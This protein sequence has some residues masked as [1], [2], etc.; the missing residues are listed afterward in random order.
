[1]IANWVPTGAGAHLRGRVIRDTQPELRLRRAVHA[2]GLRFRLNQ[3]IGQFSPDLVFSRYRLAVFVDGCYWHNCPE[4][5]PKQF[6]GPNA[7]K[8]KAKLQAN[9]AR[10][11]VA[12][13]VLE[14]AGWHV[15]RI[16]ECETRRDLDRA[17]RRV[18]TAVQSGEGR[19]TASVRRN[20]II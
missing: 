8:W 11:Q 5:G 12:N 10:D 9:Q 14:Q 6:R 19:S 20:C 1:M 13:E 16:W 17:A 4:H 7:E 18:L 15:L 2:L 3:R